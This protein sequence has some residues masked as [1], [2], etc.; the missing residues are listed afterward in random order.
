MG[1]EMPDET[2][3]IVHISKK[4]TRFLK[5]NARDLDLLDKRQLYQF[6]SGGKVPSHRVLVETALVKYIEGRKH[7]PRRPNLFRL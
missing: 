6:E 5:E 2:V 4:L 3:T 7:P 1:K